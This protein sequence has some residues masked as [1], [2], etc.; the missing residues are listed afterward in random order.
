MSGLEVCRAVRAEREIANVPVLMLTVRHDDTDVVAGLEA[1]ADDYVAKDAAG[2]DHPRAGPPADRVPADVGA[3]DAQPAARPGRPAVDGDRARDPRAAVGDPRQCRAA[4]DGGEAGEEQAQWIDSIIRS[5]RLLQVR[6]DHL[7]AAVRDSSGEMQLI[8]PRQ[9]CGRRSTCS[10]RGCRRATRPSRSSWKAQCRLPLVHG[11]AGPADAGHPQPAEQCPGGD[12][13]HRPARGGSSCG[14]GRPDDEGRS[15]VT[16]EVIDDG[17]GIPE[18]FLEPHLRAVLHHAGGGDGLRALPGRADPQGAVGPDRGPQ[19]SRPRARP[20]RIW[21]P[22]AGR[23]A[24]ARPAAAPSPGE[25]GVSPPPSPAYCSGREHA[26]PPG[27]MDGAGPGLRALAGDRRRGRRRLRQSD[28]V[29]LAL[30]GVRGRRRS[31]SSSAAWAEGAP[32]AQADPRAGGLPPVVAEVRPDAIL[33]RV[34]P[35]LGPLA[36]EVA[37]LFSAARRAAAASAGSST[38]RRTRRPRHRAP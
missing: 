21:L 22:E 7:M 16:I 12:L 24:D 9:W 28:G 30:A 36:A 38:P 19:Q 31:P 14:P 2:R 32:L 6:L 10:S 29:V 4:A 13:A 18:A 5:T 3:G 23:T 26:P 35:A 25:T 33:G 15:W 1:G 8:D 34:P 27:P 17:P 37:A 11:D 20:S